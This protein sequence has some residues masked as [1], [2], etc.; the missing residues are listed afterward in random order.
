MNDLKSKTF[1]ALKWDLLGK[2]INHG[3]IFIFSI[4]LARLLSPEDFGIMGISMVFIVLAQA[5]LSFGLSSALVQNKN[6]TQE[7][8]CTVFYLNL[9]LGMCMAI[10]LFS[11]SGFIAGYY[12]KDII[13]PILRVLS[14]LFI[15]N[16]FNIVQNALLIKNLNFQI[17]TRANVI[18]AVVSGIIGISLAVTGYGVWSLVIKTIF[19]SILTTIIIWY[20]ATWRPLLIFNLRSIK[21][22]WNYGY[23]LFLSGVI[24]NIYERID[25]LIIGKIFS[26][27]SLGYYERAKSFNQLI[28]NFSSQSL[29]AVLFPVFSTIQDN[30]EKV[31]TTVAKALNSL[32]FIV[33]GMMGVLY[34]TAADLIF[35]LFGEKWLPSIAFFKILIF[36]AYCYPVSA[37]LVNVISGMGNSTAFLKLEILKKIFLTFALTIGFLFG[38]KGYLVALAIVG[39][40]GIYLNIWFV[41][42]QID[43]SVRKQYKDIFMYAIP[44]CVSTVITYFLAHNI[45]NNHILHL[46]ITGVLFAIGYLIINLLLRTKGFIFFQELLLIKLRHKKSWHILNFFSTR[47]A[48]TKKR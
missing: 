21:R 30:L 33:F 7:Q 4:V 23:K 40:I 1:R 44:S 43:Y 29:T 34:L 26:I 9:A 48:V 13:K 31:R 14:F 39:F 41:Q 2:F 45:Q 8:Y 15:I 22:L 5:F 25:V 10:A 28:V 11:M 35:L 17:I 46:I 16:S 18:S 37:V 38:I 20:F 42:K 6:T 12:K 19:G 3:S 27:V 32:S 47:N 36:Y 24:N